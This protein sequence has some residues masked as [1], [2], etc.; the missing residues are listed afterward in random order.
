MSDRSISKLRGTQDRLEADC[1]SFRILE[2]T[3]QDLLSSYGYQVVDTPVLEPAE[4]YLLKSGA[5]VASQMYTFV[6]PGGRRVALRPEFTASVIRAFIQ[7]RQGGDLPLR[8]QYCGP[9]FRY[10]PLQ[11]GTFRQFHQLGAELIGSPGPRA[12]AE[13]VSLAYKGV[14]EAGLTSYQLVLGH[15]GVIL[16]LLQGLG[17]S[18]RARAFLASNIGELGRGADWIE[19]VRERSRILGLE[20]MGGKEQL[21]DIVTDDMG[22]EEARAVLLGLMRGLEDTVGSRDREEI[23]A[24]FLRKANRPED[25]ARVEKGI[26]LVSRLSSIRGEP[27]KALA[28]CSHL[29]RDL[30]VRDP[31][32]ETL[33]TLEDALSALTD[34]GIPEAELTFDFGLARDLAYYTGVVFEIRHPSLPKGSTLCGGGRY[35]GLVKALGG[36][37]DSPAL[38]FAYSLDNLHLATAA[39]GV[40][41]SAAEMTL[42]DLL[43][44]PADERSYSRALAEAERLR[45]QGKRVEL[46][47]CGLSQEQSLNYAEGRGIP[48]VVVVSQSGE[49]D[50]QQA[51]LTSN[52]AAGPS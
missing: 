42:I 24:R 33:G 28:E 31:K 43:V 52:V 44:V 10:G 49:V 50:I 47:L 21:L 38:G 48:R 46:G 35:D 2:A 39:E 5:E 26:L 32:G 7:N 40:T 19:G 12:D 22:E 51:G 41:P 45:G 4:L 23:V 17:L 18:D 14:K 8:W 34:G 13:V 6:D 27:A 29:L 1:A 9:V 16:M 3:L 30:G 15:V 36:A 11:D 20:G 25:P 37:E